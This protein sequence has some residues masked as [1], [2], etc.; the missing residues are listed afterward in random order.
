MKYSLVIF[1]LDGT[2]VDTSEGLVSSMKYIAE[3]RNLRKYEDNQLKFF[4]GP[5]IQITFADKFGLSVQEANE[6]AVDFRTHYKEIDLLKAKPYDGIFELF[7]ELRK[8]NIITAIA[9]NKRE[10][11]M[12]DL[13][14]HYGIDKCIDIFNGTDMAQTLTKS[15]LIKK[16]ISESGIKTQKEAVMVGDAIGDA[17]GAEEAGIDFV[18]AAYGFG[19]NSEKEIKEA[20]EIGFIN[21]PLDLLGILN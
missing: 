3:Q 4:I 17:K 5:P 12:M 20:D 14:R 21:R 1:D 16:C 8:M 9:T 10:D 18:R 2:I 7:G 19:F 15:D 6:A 13:L 11:Y